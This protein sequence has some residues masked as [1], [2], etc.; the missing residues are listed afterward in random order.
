MVAALTLKLS[1]GA[2]LPDVYFE[3][4]PC[5]GVFVAG[6]SE[7][8]IGAIVTVTIEFPLDSFRLRGKVAWRRLRPGHR[9]GLEAGIGVA[10]LPDQAVAVKRL[11]G[12]AQHNP[13]H[14]TIR[15]DRRVPMKLK[16]RYDSFLSLARDFVQDGSLGGLRISSPTPPPVGQPVVLYLRPPRTLTPLRLV[17]QVVW[18]KSEGEDPC[19]G[20][21][22]TGTSL[23]DRKR[24]ERLFLRA[25]GEQR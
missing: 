2:Q 4:V 8:P 23:R 10:F 19:F 13:E 22:F 12:Y 21:R 25:S 7:L 16:V 18:R 14:L 1:R 20:V 3:H 17:G 6:S 15:L 11:L 9:K 24:V 5:G